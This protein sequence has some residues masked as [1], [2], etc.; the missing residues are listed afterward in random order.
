MWLLLEGE[1]VAMPRPYPPEFRQRRW[2]WSAQAVPSLR[3][4]GCSGSL[5]PVPLEAAGPDRPVLKL[6]TGRAE[7]AELAAARQKIRELEEENKILRK[8]AAAAGQ[9]VPPKERFRLVAELHGDGVRVRQACYAPGVSPSGCCDR[10]TRAPS[11]RPVRHAW[12]TGLTG[13]ARGA[14]CGTCGQPQVRAGLQRAYGV[15]AGRNTVAPL[16]RRAGI[17]GLPLRRRAKTVPSHKT[18]TGLVKRQFTAAGPN[19]LWVTGITGHPT[20]EGKPCCCVVTGVFSRRLVGWA[21]GSTQ[22]A[23]L[24]ASALA[25]PPA[26]AGPPRAPSSTAT[27]DHGTQFTSWAFPSRAGNAGLLPSPGT[28][29]DPYD[30]AVAGSSWG[31]MQAGLP[32]R[33]R[34]STRAGLANAVFEYIEGSRNRRRRHSALG[35]AVPLEFETQHRHRAATPHEPL[36]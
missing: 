13:Q 36:R 25:W 30:N 16:M 19:R 22:K 12:L 15:T 14:S 10:K 32:N 4:P 8:A 28:V 1:V 33:R 20:R 27:T 23:G 35:W 7:S 17:S 26:P 11:A 31:H 5:V 9:V 6:R 24:A 29:G 3:S 18:V 2:T 21:T 34:W